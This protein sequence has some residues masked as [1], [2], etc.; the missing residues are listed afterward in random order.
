MDIQ[1][2]LKQG[3]A[4]NNLPG[5]L[6]NVT[7]LNP[8][9]KLPFNCTG[10][11]GTQCCVT[12]SPILLT[13]PHIIRINLAL[14]QRET[15][16]GNR[17]KIML[18]L[19]SKHMPFDYYLGKNSSLPWSIINPV[20]TQDGVRCCPFMEIIFIGQKVLGQCGVYNA[21]PN[22][23]R[24]FPL[25]RVSSTESP[26]NGGPEIQYIL[27]KCNTSCP[28][29]TPA[30]KGELVH[31]S[32]KFDPDQTVIEYMNKQLDRNQDLEDEIWFSQIITKSLAV[33]QNSNST[34]PQLLGELLYSGHPKIEINAQETEIHE[35]ILRWLKYVED[36]LDV[37]V[38]SIKPAEEIESPIPVEPLIETE[39]I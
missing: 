36:E 10:G 9:D 31:H 34:M 19:N 8:S 37:L 18:D 39:V 7:E 21:R 23:C 30:A 27:P 38:S 25:A 13:A 24:T 29:W 5:Y 4:D 32:Y 11:C 2:V 22:T 20:I 1:K 3:I 12:D 35:T 6:D 15:N 17:P 14:K 16:G 26:K 33:I 28:G